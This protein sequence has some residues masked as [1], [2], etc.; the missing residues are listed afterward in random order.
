MAINILKKKD[1]IHVPEH[2][3][4]S[5]FWVLV[6]VVLRHTYHDDSE[7]DEACGNVF[8]YGNDKQS[9]TT[10]L[11]F[12][13]DDDTYLG[14]KDNAP[15]TQLLREFKDIMRY[16]HNMQAP[17]VPLTHDTVL[18]IFDKALDMEGWPTDDEARPVVL[19][20]KKTTNVNRGQTA[21]K[22]GSKKRKEENMGKTGSSKRSKRS[23]E[24]KSNGTSTRRRG[25]GR[26]GS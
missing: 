22:S 10:K 19:Q 13:G 8:I 1:A 24:S 23:S 16:R 5:F 18:A 25:R 11:G 26:R 4:E 20:S 3:L 6:W 7:G 12:L 17:P 9:Y 21:S 2:D 14:V 15:L